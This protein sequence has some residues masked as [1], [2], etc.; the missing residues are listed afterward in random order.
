MRFDYDNKSIIEKF[1]AAAILANEWR[2]TLSYTALAVGGIE[3]IQY[4]KNLAAAPLMI[5]SL[6]EASRATLWRCSNEKRL[7]D[8]RSPVIDKRVLVSAATATGFS[9]VTMANL[10]SPTQG[11]LNGPLVDFVN[12]AIA[13]MC[14]LVAGGPRGALESYTKVMWDYPRKKGGGGTTQTQRLKDG[15]SKLAGQIAG[16]FGGMAPQP[17]AR[18]ALPIRALRRTATAG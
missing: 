2:D 1:A 5:A 7:V 18:K 13:S 12:M 11:L 8:D 9:L 16:G 15:F 6:R 3:L 4:N 17:T 10:A 14:L